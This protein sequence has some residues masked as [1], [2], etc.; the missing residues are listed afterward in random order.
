MDRKEEENKRVPTAS[1][2][3]VFRFITLLHTLR[4]VVYYNPFCCAVIITKENAPLLTEITLLF[5]LATGE[6]R[7]SNW[8]V[9]HQQVLY[10]GI[11]G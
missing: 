5:G 1:L 11:L 9:V 10:N 6:C 8:A 4:V 7:I 2:E 3:I